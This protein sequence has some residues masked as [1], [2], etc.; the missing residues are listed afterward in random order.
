MDTQIERHD[1]ERGG[2]QYVLLHDGKPIGELDYTDTEGRR[3]FTHT[4]VRDGYEG[5]GLAGQLVKR[6]LGDAR[7]ED[8]EI[9]AQCSYVAR[10]LERHPE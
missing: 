1:D 8:R 6:A 4:G 5:K 9:V 2:G 3:N 7:D 10:Y